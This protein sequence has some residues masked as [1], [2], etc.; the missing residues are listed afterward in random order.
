MSERPSPPPADQNI[1]VHVRINL[2]H[3][4]I[5]LSAA[6]TLF[7]L[8][9]IPN[10]EPLDNYSLELIAWGV[11]I[12]LLLAAL[13][14]L[15]R[16]RAI[17]PST[18]SRQDWFIFGGLV[19]AAFLLR[20]WRI[21]SIPFTMSGDESSQAMESL[22]VIQGLIRNPFTTGWYTVP[23]MNFFFNSLFLAVIPDKFIGLR[24]P[25]ALIGSFT[26]GG[27]Y[28]LV[29]QITGRR[30]AILTS[31]LTLTYHYHI[32]YSRV[33]SNQI[34]D[35]LFMVLAL[36][37]LYRGMKENR[38]VFW[39]LG[40]VITG[41]AMYAYAGAR[42]TLLVVSA[43]LVFLT[44]RSPG[45][46]IQQHWRGALLFYMGFLI[47][48][49][50]MLQF[51]VL[52]PDDFN[53]RINQIGIIQSG[54]L[55]REAETY[56]VSQISILW[57]QFYRSFF[58]LTYY[59]D[60][61]VWYKPDTP[62]LDP[63]SSV[64]LIFGLLYATIAL[65]K[66]QK[67]LPFAV[68]WWGG[69]L[70]GSMLTESPPSSQRL[71]TLIV[72]SLFFVAFAADRLI[73]LLRRAL[74][75]LR[76]SILYAI[77]LLAFASNSLFFYFGEY[78]PRRAFG[79]GQAETATILAPYI[80]AAEGKY[81]VYLLPDANTNTEFPTWAYLFEGPYILLKEPLTF[82]LQ[83][84]GL[85]DGKGALFIAFPSRFAELDLL[86]EQVPGGQLTHINSQSIWK[87]EFMLYFIPPAQDPSDG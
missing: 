56:Q 5:V 54:W 87:S 45:K 86:R 82:P 26:V 46:F 3:L 24:L 7:T 74:P 36:Y 85:S 21:S 66:N 64:L 55:A 18:L 15:D 69:T 30:L 50:Q 34:A 78:T 77:L 14:W 11:S 28:L 61:T 79:G 27:V 83:V 62:L 22:R 60:R 16:S 13:Y 68:W 20:F 42:L 70:L 38:F 31:L 19:L 65:F 6:L 4:L 43:I 32:H 73:Q 37:F 41:L 1:S 67:F 48:G 51:G 35:P 40:G 57:E 72:P 23:T 25:Y 49:A 47:T 76:G 9:Q 33:G 12:L 75:H 84:E 53:A 29:R 8:F 44:A 17:L 81:P 10:K 59:Q 63:V 71:V 58:G 52:H 2:V 39:G 80:N